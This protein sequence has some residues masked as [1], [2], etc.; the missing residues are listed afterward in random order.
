M[1]SIKETIDKQICLQTMRQY[2]RDKGLKFQENKSKN[3]I[4]FTIL[5]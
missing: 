5:V 4:E 2:M 1:D 3:S